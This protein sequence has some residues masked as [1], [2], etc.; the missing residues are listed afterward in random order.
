VATIKRAAI[1][2]RRN[3]IGFIALA[4]LAV[5]L[6]VVANFAF[7]SPPQIGTSEQVFNTVDALYTAVRNE[8]EKR[9]GECEQ[10]LRGYRETG[11]LPADAA[12]TLDAIIATARAAKWRVAAESLYGFMSGQRREG[13]IGHDHAHDKKGQYKKGQYKKQ[14]LGQ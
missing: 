7:R 14:G 13:E 8:D 12:D 10:R 9:L 4:A 11:K 2:S 1:A 3:K 5:L 6:S